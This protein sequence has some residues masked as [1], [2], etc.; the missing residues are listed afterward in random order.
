M[1]EDIGWEEHYAT[2]AGHRM[3]PSEE[4]VRW[5]SGRRFDRI[6]DVGAGTGANYWL[7]TRHCPPG[8]LMSI[9]PDPS[10]RRTFLNRCDIAD[11]SIGLMDLH[12]DTLPQQW[13]EGYGLVVDCMT[14]QHIK[15]AE[16]GKVY[17]EYA[18][19]LKPGGWFFLLHLDSKTQ[20]EIRLPEPTG[21]GS[22]DSAICDY[23]ELS[24]FPSLS[25]FCLPIPQALAEAVSGG[26]L[27]VQEM[28]G[29][30]REYP[31]GDR[32]HYTIIAARKVEQ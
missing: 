26:G 27:R 1:T 4:L 14:S 25:L 6:L 9:E 2:K 19:V 5:I 12:A 3:W 21:P 22:W 23:Y 7:L 31:N 29:L 28:R 30:A 18:R 11:E 17:A 8:G 13:T 24:L 10:A 32:A 16:H 20:C 15:W